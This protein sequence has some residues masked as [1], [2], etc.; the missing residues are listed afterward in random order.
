MVFLIALSVNGTLGLLSEGDDRRADTAI[1]E[2]D[3]WDV[4]RGEEGDRILV[5]LPRAELE[6]PSSLVAKGKLF[7]GLLEGKEGR[8]V[9]GG[10][11]TGGC[12]G[13]GS[14]VATTVV[15]LPLPRTRF[16]TRLRSI[17]RGIGEV[18]RIVFTVSIAYSINAR[19]DMLQRTAIEMVAALRVGFADRGRG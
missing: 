12:D 9:L 2:P 17:R 5:G 6:S 10:S 19:K 8:A 4:R 18:N 7:R 11:M 1:A 16:Q 14:D 15:I 13:K 3:N